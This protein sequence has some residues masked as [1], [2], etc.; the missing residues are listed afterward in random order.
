MK[1][2]CYCFIY[3]NMK[4]HNTF[5]RFLGLALTLSLIITQSASA[6]AQPNQGYEDVVRTNFNPEE[7]P[8]SDTNINSIAGI[9]AA[10][11]YYR[12]VIGG[13][14]DGEFKGRQLVNRAEAAKFLLLAAN[15]PLSSSVTSNQ[16]RDVI[17]TEWY[18]KYVI[19]AAENNIIKGYSDNTFRPAKSVLTAE[20]LKMISL[21][22]DLETNLPFD[23]QDVSQFPGAWFWDYAGA[24]QKYELFPHR[25]TALR[26]DSELTRNEVAVAMYQLLKNKNIDVSSII[27]N[28]PNT[29]NSN[30]PQN[31]NTNVNSSSSNSSTNTA[32]V[33][34]TISYKPLT[35]TTL[36]NGKREVIRFQL[37]AKTDMT[38]NE[39]FIQMKPSGNINWSS[40]ELQESGG[41]S[42]SSVRSSSKNR[43]L[44]PL[45]NNIF[46]KANQFREFVVYANISGYD[47]NAQLIGQ[48]VELSINGKSYGDYLPYSSDLIKAVQTTA[49]NNSSSSSGSQNQSTNNNSSSSNTSSASNNA[50]ST[51]SSS[52]SNNTNNSNTSS[53]ITP[54]V[55]IVDQSQT[56]SQYIAQNS[57]ETAATY[58]L[59]FKITT[60]NAGA[61]LKKLTIPAATSNGRSL[62]SM[63]STIDLQINGVTLSRAI[64][65]TRTVT[66]DGLNIPINLN[67]NQVFSLLAKPRRVIT[68]GAINGDRFKFFIPE[69][70]L[71]VASGSLITTTNGTIINPSTPSFYTAHEFSI[72]GA[73]VSFESGGAID[74]DLLNTGRQQFLKFRMSKT[75]V[76]T[77]EIGD[78]LPS[79][80]I[81]FEINKT[82][83]T[84]LSFCEIVDSLNQSL[85]SSSTFTSDSEG[86]NSAPS[87]ASTSTGFVTFTSNHFFPGKRIEGGAGNSYTLYC[88]VNAPVSSSDLIQISLTNNVNIGVMD[89]EVFMMNENNFFL[90]LPITGT[91]RVAP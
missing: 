12:G 28:T 84:Q 80:H 91:P 34:Y 52:S 50:N 9:A 64:P 27:I 38:L 45:S 23:Y 89:N 83:K 68:G 78:G 1:L 86:R 75:G 26:P 25:Q 44:L 79:S 43:I 48:V 47:Q 39:V 66:F 46:F 13:F 61:T 40:F 76:G 5:K 70:M 32:Q 24:A 7:N 16:F 62:S 71:Q 73:A 53:V 59:T 11:L 6:L 72:Q 88:T 63:I 29:S 69:N 41:R 8:F 30:T 33:K 74:S 85:A 54:S 60:A 14:P 37:S 57:A 81:Q 31:S 17:P 55:T 19:T 21:S 67:D 3:L 35:S 87:L 10:E 51:N 4:S 22:F 20:F 90:G 15:I 65:D 56:R 2:P 82:S 18:G 36:E 42:L 58:V 49:P 77:A